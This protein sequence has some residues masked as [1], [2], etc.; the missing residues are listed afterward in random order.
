VKYNLVQQILKSEPVY[1]IPDSAH[2][3][4]RANGWRNTAVGFSKLL[5]YGYY[6][7]G[8]ISIVRDN[9]N[10]SNYEVR[11]SYD[12]LSRLTASACRR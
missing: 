6:S 12:K 8:N 3:I 10:G 11:Y 2:T 1:P 5:E 9:V 7:S 4:P